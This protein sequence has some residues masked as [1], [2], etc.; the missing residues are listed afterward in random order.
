MIIKC[1][2]FIFLLKYYFNILSFVL[3]QRNV[4]KIYQEILAPIAKIDE[5]IQTSVKSC[6]SPIYFDD[7]D[8][9]SI[10]QNFH[11]FSHQINQYFIYF[12]EIKLMF[13]IIFFYFLKLI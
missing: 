13:K 2:K 11:L 5:D 8:R 10:N 3:K 7:I 1:L 12:I 6:I 9:F 4:K